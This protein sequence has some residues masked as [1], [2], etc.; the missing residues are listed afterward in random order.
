MRSRDP[1]VMIWALFD[2]AVLADEYGSLTKAARIPGTLLA[3]MQTPIP[4][5]TERVRSGIGVRYFGNII[6]IG[7]I[8]SQYLGQAFACAIGIFAV[9]P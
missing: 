1:K 9:C 8:S 5:P 7:K 4:V 2:V 3:E 6:P